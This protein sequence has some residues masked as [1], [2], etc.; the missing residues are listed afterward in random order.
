MSTTQYVIGSA[1]LIGAMFLKLPILIWGWPSGW[2]AYVGT[3]P[4][5]FISGI[6]LWGSYGNWLPFFLGFMGIVGIVVSRARDAKKA[7][8]AGREEGRGE[9]AV[10][11]SPRPLA[12]RAGES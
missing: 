1:I 5:Y 10:P 4:L 9:L 3:P 6:V 2:R 7:A 12:A 11:P 8:G